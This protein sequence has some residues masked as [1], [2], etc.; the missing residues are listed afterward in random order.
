MTT[1]GVIPLILEPKELTSHLSTLVVFGFVLLVICASLITGAA[2]R[3]LSSVAD[4]GSTAHAQILADGIAIRVQRAVAVGVPLAKLEG[5]N[6]FFA[7]RMQSQPGIAAL[8]LLDVDGKVVFQLP[9]DADINTV[10]GKQVTA[11]AVVAGSTVAKVVLVWRQTEIWLLL[12]R[13]M[14]PITAIVMIFSLIAAEVLRCAMGRSILFRD[15]QVTLACERVE[16]GDFSWRFERTIQHHFDQRM[17]WISTELKHLNELYLRVQRMVQ[18]LRQTEPDAYQRAHL[19]TLLQQATA[20][21]HFRSDNAPLILEPGQLMQKSERLTGVF[22]SVLIWI[23]LGGITV[24]KFNGWNENLSVLTTLTLGLVILLWIG[25]R[26]Y[27]LKT[28]NRYFLSGAIVGG[29]AVGPGLLLSFFVLFSTGQ[30]TL[31][32]WISRFA[33]C[34][35]ILAS[36]FLLHRSK[37]ALLHSC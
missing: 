12:S 28:G 7:Q 10:S 4:T 15:A 16:M 6:A 18:S 26:H 29:L 17:A 21:D 25:W 33:L 36:G 13:W 9:S 37:Q 31:V 1:N 30:S 19:D 3:Q 23:C 14:L 5:L 11:T 20:S 34:G 32:Y 27:R 24:L 2:L 35:I 22:V 8:I